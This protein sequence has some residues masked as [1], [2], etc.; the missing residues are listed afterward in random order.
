MSTP[1]EDGAPKLPPVEDSA[2]KLPPVE[3]GAPKLPPVEDGTPVELDL[4]L[5]DHGPKYLESR[6]EAE[7]GDVALFG[8]PF[9]GTTSFRPGTRFGPDHIRSASIVLESYSP[10]QDRDLADIGYCDLGNLEVPMGPPGPMVEGVEAATE[11]LLAAGL[12]PL[13]LGGEHSISTGAVTAVQR[14]YPDLLL[15]QLDA[16]G[17]LRESYLGQ[18]HNHACTMR[19]C[20]SVVGPRGLIQVG[21]RSGTRDEF[22]EMRAEDRVVE[23]HTAGYA[24]GLRAPTPDGR[25]SGGERGAHEAHPM[26]RKLADLI[27]ARGERPIYLTVDLDVF[28]PGVL[29]GTGTPEPGG[30][31][32]PDFRAI[33]DAIPE[34]RL[35]AAD[36]V[37]LSPGLDPTAGSSVYAAKVVR[38]VALRL[39]HD[40]AARKARALRSTP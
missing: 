40:R 17:D 24:G 35:V 4:P 1:V 25:S 20:L 11:A 22:V 9:D 38:E 23:P 28:D 37:E 2:P 30:I 14:R 3:D 18:H 21:I 36:V 29:P 6:R 27:A 15:V 39:A 7:V 26:A 31:F 33:L 13:M 5:D 19:R 34:G 32:W 10:D 8:V 12:V 16:H